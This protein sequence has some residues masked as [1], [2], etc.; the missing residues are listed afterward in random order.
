M[1]EFVT[2]EVDLDEQLP[3]RIWS[4]LVRW[5]AE[6]I[7][8]DCE[9]TGTVQEIHAHHI[10]ENKKN[11][12]LRNGVC[13]CS[14]CHARRH[15]RSGQKGNPSKMGQVLSL[16]TRRKISEAAKRRWAGYDREKR[17]EITAPGRVAARGIRRY[18]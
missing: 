1:A 3:L 2:I 7:C 11:N 5:L 12:C 14:S 18:G 8:Q 17:L 16:D 13:L 9:A 15:N 6:N 10:D 4:Q